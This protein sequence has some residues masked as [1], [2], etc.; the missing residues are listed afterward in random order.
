MRYR[1]IAIAVLLLGFSARAATTTQTSQ[2]VLPK[3]T[4]TLDKFPNAPGFQLLQ[5]TVTAGERRFAMTY[6]LFVPAVYFSSKDPFPLVTTL[7]NRYAIGLG[8]RNLCGEGFG[9]HL[10]EENW[11]DNGPGMPKNPILIRKMVRFIGLAPQ[12]PP[13][14][15]WE[16]WPMPQ[17]IDQLIA[18][19][20]KEARIDDDR[21][22]LT[23]FS[24]GGTCTWA[25]AEMMPDRFAAIVPISGR[26]T[27]EPARTVETLRHLPIWLAAGTQDWALPHCQQMNDAL[28][29]G[30]HPS[31]VY[32]EIKD[33]THFCYPTIYTDPKFWEWLLAQR[34]SQRPK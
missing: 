26:A 25:I 19:L 18:E 9:K 13:G 15:A 33:G 22:Y 23:G 2:P 4:V 8:G 28:A 30:K 27:A 32:R 7:H 1:L 3:V 31:F 6:G 34:R 10:F 16:T 12:C 29:A 20:G 14:C 21:L 11:I 17:V 24:Y 5:C